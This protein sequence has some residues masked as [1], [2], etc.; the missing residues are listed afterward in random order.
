[1]VVQICLIPN[2]MFPKPPLPDGSF[3]P[4]NAWLTSNIPWANLL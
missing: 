1:M 3:S 2:G 4:F